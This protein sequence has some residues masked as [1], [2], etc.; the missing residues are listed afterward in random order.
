MPGVTLNS[1]PPEAYSPQDVLSP[2]AMAYQRQ[3]ALQARQRASMPTPPHTPTPYPGQAEIQELERQQRA[4][5]ASGLPQNVQSY[6][7]TQPSQQEWEAL[8]NPQ[9]VPYPSGNDEGD[10]IAS[11]ASP[12]TPPDINQYRLRGWDDPGGARLQSRGLGWPA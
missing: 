12:V 3:Q 5:Q 11:P 7:S 1:L 10:A 8:V 6:M 9:R 2:A 4:I